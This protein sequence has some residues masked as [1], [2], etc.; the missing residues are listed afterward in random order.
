MRIFSKDFKIIRV[1]DVGP[2]HYRGRYLLLA[3]DGE[4]WGGDR[5]RANRGVASWK[6]GD[7]ITVR[8]MLVGNNQ[9]D[10]WIVPDWAAVA[11]GQQVKQNLLRPYV[12]VAQWWGEDVAARHLDPT[13]PARET[14]RVLP[15]PKV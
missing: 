4:S 7:I 15:M 12:D 3:E 5:L 10:R 14:Y 8:M 13:P 6:V 1:E 2:N 9:G 11:A